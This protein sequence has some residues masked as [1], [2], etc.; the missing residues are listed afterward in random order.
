MGD[1]SSYPV[2]EA[3][4]RALRQELGELR[5][6]QK[7]VLRAVEEMTQTFRSLAVQLGLASE[8]YKKG[9][10]RAERRESPGFA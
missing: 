5:D 7:A 4:I 6:E 1:A 3:E 9:A 2:L 8:P 10:A